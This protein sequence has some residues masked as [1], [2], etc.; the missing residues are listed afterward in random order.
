[1]TYLE[2]L[3]RG[4]P[5]PQGTARA[6]MAGGRAIV[7]TEANRT[8]SPLGAWR[9]SIATEAR[10]AIGEHPL[11]AGPVRVSIVF[12]MPRPRGHYLPANGKRPEP[13][14]RLDAPQ[15]H[16]GTPDSD[17][18]GRSALDALTSVVFGDDAQVADLRVKKVYAGD[19]TGARIFVDALEVTA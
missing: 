8:S 14:L 2:I 15:W 1:M 10:A 19:W 13:V 4:L 12:L 5:V 16:I 7:T 17:K 18:L 3:V 6:F 9:A 11:M